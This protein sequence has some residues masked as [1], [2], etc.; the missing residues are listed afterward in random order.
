[1]HACRPSAHAISR[2][3]SYA[4]AALTK[5]LAIVE[6]QACRSRRCGALRTRT[7]THADP[8]P[9]WGPWRSGRG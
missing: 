8:R 1:M 5:L 6:H 9:R 4:D 3:H 7:V 2:V